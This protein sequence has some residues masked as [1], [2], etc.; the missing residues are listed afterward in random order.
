MPRFCD[1]NAK[2]MTFVYRITSF[3]NI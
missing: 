3:N 1:I 2:I